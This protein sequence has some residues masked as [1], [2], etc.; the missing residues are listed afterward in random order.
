M[1]P[2]FNSFRDTYNEFEHE[3]MKYYLQL[4]RFQT[5]NLLNAIVNGQS[6]KLG[7]INEGFP[8]VSFLDLTR[9][10][11]EHSQIISKYIFIYI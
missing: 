5:L 7:T 1:E 3:I 10:A 9:S 11:N 4:S 8:Q 2:L 6:F